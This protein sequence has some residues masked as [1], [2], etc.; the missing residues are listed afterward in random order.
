MGIKTH[1]KHLYPYKR[2]A[3][4]S[5][6]HLTRPDINCLRQSVHVQFM[7]TNDVKHIEPNNK[8]IFK[9]VSIRKIKKRQ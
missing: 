4:T 7:S 6:D 8:K 5:D 2:S 9:R 1:K 3:G